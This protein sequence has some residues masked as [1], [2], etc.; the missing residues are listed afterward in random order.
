LLYAAHWSL[1][2]DSRHETTILDR[3]GRIRACPPT[4][5]HRLVG[6]G[7]AVAFRLI[8]DNQ[9]CLGRG[10]ADVSEATPELTYRRLYS[11]P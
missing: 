6:V 5:I 8:R 4:P 10:R 2:A 9:K 7:S 1:S 3:W 11:R